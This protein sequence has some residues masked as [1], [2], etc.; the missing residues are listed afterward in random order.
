MDTPQQRVDPGQ[1]L[2]RVKRLHE[3]IVRARAESSD[4]VRNL[5]T[6]R[7]HKDAPVE[8]VLPGGM[9]DLKAVQT[10]QHHI[11]NQQVELL[12]QSEVTTTNAIQR[13]FHLVSRGPEKVRDGQHQA[14]LIFHE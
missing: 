1:Q 4:T 7:K 14:R 12:L 10:R 11:Q 9:A 5:G 3:V 8:A 13:S 6:R 2:L